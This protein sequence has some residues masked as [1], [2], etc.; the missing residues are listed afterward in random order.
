MLGMRT[1][2]HS[3]AQTPGLQR[4]CSSSPV[5]PAH[6]H[7]RAHTYSS[8]TTGLPKGVVLTHRN[9]VANVEQC[10]VPELVRLNDET[11][12]V[13]VLPFYHIYG[14]TCI[15]HISLSLGAHITCMERFDPIEFLRIL[16][17]E[18]VNIVHAVPPMLVFLA[19]HPMVDQYDITSVR[20][21]FSGAA[22][23]TAD[24]CELLHA[25]FPHLEVVRCA[26]PIFIA[27]FSLLACS[28]SAPSLLFL[29][30]SA[31]PRP[32]R[33]TSASSCTRD[34]LILRS[35]GAPLLVLSFP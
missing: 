34:S 9:I 4:S 23:L 15:M 19:K 13:G 31:A 35:S 18:K 32:S 22:P 33:P 7:T 11:S 27:L 20:E 5:F 28:R 17:D 26:A 29:R 6:T 30:S 16:Q 10:S 2:S 3:H 12:L 24:V 21:I 25:R 8:G 14:Q 1:P